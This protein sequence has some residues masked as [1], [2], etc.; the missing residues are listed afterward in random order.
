MCDKCALYLILKWKDRHGFLRIQMERCS[1]DESFF[2]E[3]AAFGS[4]LSHFYVRR[5]ASVIKTC[6]SRD[7]DLRYPGME[8]LHFD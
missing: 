1:S 3:S 7:E 2:L 5:Q 6:A 8:S 4:I